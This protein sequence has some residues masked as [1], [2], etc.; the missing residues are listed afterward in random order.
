MNSA[1]KSNRRQFL[2]GRSAVQ[3]VRQLTHTLGT[4]VGTSPLGDEAGA[5]SVERSP[6]LMQLSRRAM[7]CDFQIFLHAS[8][9]QGAIEAANESLELLETLEDQMTVYR[10]HSEVSTINRLAA[11]RPC[12]VEPQLFELLRRCVT[13]HGVTNGA[14]DITSGP[15]VKLWGFHRRQ[16]RFPPPEE[17]DETLQRVGSQHLQLDSGT[18]TIHFKRPGMELNLGSV[19][20]GYALD[21]CRQLLQRAGVDAFLIHGGQSSILAH[22]ARSTSDPASAWH[23]ALCDPLRPDRKL[24]ELVLR[25]RAVGTSGNARQ[26]FY[27][28][29]RRYGHVIDPRCGTPAEDV[30]SVSV[31]APSAAE[32]DALATGFFVLGVDAARAICAARSDLGAV[33]VLPGSRPGSVQLEVISLADSLIVDDDTASIVEGR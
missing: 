17:I 7:A 15:L 11:T 4:T 19:G 18:L 29:G 22:G 3:A 14:F 1:W 12:P 10:E 28:Q 31:L 13:W 33:F 32:A 27:H 6:Y 5:T 9:P 30:L 16:G 26:F 25:D 23:I 24:G 8:P 2:Q 21:R 20:K